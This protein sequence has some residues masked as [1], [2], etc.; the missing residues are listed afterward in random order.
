MNCVRRFCDKRKVGHGLHAREK[1]L[2]VEQVR[3]EEVQNY[4]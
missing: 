4:R 2:F 3:V 1:N